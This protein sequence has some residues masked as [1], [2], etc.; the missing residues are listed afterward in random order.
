M[1]V[2]RLVTMGWV[3]H[4][5]TAASTSLLF[6]PR[7]CGPWYDGIDWG[8]FITCL[9][10]R[11]GSH[12]YSGGPVSGDISGAS[13]RVGE[14]NENVVFPSPW[15]LK[16]SLTCRKILRHGTYGF[17]SH[18]KEGVLRIFI[19]LKGPSPW[20]GSNPRPLCPVANTNLYTTEATSFTVVGYLPMAESGTPQRQGRRVVN[21]VTCRAWRLCR[22]VSPVVDWRMFFHS[23]QWG[24]RWTLTALFQMALQDPLRPACN[25]D[26]RSTERGIGP[27]TFCVH[28]M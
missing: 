11:F 2:G 24:W 6:I 12:Q 14:G 5:R 20:P 27:F 4:L 21:H 13:W 26:L 15:N 16:R 7:W 18:P 10:Q 22:I 17:A 28:W 9:P 23:A 25:K 8:Y 3:W 19:T 1:F